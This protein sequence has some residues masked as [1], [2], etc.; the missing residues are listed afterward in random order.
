MSLMIK[1]VVLRST[2]VALTP[3]LIGGG[4]GGGGGGGVCVCVCVC[5]WVVR[6]DVMVRTV[7]STIYCVCVVATSLRLHEN[8]Q[9]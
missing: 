2:G 8:E 6:T 1:R 7:L 4:G 5:S 9:T 3:A